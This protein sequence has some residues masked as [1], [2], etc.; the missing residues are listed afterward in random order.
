MSRR[1]KNSQK[2]R[3]RDPVAAEL[4]QSAHLRRRRVVPSKRRELD[5]RRDIAERMRDA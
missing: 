1:R 3:R 2:P 4:V 5:R